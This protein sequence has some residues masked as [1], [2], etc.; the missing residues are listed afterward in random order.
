MGSVPWVIL[1]VAPDFVADEAFVVLS[2]F[3][4]FYG[5][6]LDGV[7]VHGIRVLHCPGKKGPDATFSSKGSNSFLLSM[8]FA[9][10]PNPFIQHDGD[11]FD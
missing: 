10:L 7:N 6:E 8:E 2:M 4:F 3:C 9:C 11:V 1:C 5:E